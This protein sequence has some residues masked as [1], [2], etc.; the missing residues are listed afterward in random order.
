[1]ASSIPAT[2]D[3]EVPQPSPLVHRVF[4]EPRFHT[5]GDIAAVAFAA[6]GRQLARHF[7]S[8]LETL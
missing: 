2:D 3:P 8:D 5:E 6:D 7:L 1:M 4:G